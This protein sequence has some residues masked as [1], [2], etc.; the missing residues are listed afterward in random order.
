MGIA[1]RA[2]SDVVAPFAVFGSVAY[3]AIQMRQLNA[4]S[5]GESREA[6]AL[7][8]QQELFKIIDD[9]ETF[10]AFTKDQLTITEKIRLNEWLIASLEQR[11][12]QWHQYRNEILDRETFETY[13]EVLAIIL[14]TE[15]TTHWWNFSK[16]DAFD[17]DFAKYVDDLL[18]KR[19]RTKFFESVHEWD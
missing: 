2:V 9:P 13:S 17:L 6:S 7:S 8:A 14:G 3:L 15:R 10:E 16:T 12:Y 11:K 18:S 4:L 19:G 1:A 5:R